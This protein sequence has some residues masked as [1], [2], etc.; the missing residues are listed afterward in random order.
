MLPRERLPVK[1]WAAFFAESDIKSI[2]RMIRV[3]QNTVARSVKTQ[4]AVIT[5]EK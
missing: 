5:Y 1:Y 2:L 4:A 3:N